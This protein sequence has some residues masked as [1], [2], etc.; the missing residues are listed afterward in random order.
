MSRLSGVDASFLYLESADMPMHVAGLTLYE[1]PPGF[2]GSFHAHFKAFFAGRVHLI[3]IFGKKLAHAPLNLDHPGWVDEDDLDLDYHIQGV[4]LP[5]PGTRA[6]LDAL[7]ARMHAQLMDRSKPL[8][9]FTV[10]EG[11]EDGRAALYSKVHH[12]AVDGS[13]G[14]IITR[15]L[16]DLTPEPRVVEPP[17]PKAPSPAQ[18]PK[19]LSTSLTDLMAGMIRQ[20]QAA[21]RAMPDML[22][23]LVNAVAPP[24]GKDTPITELFPNIKLPKL[25]FIAPKT[26]FNTTVG[27]ARAYASRSLLLADAKRIAKATDTKINDVVMAISGGALRKYLA[28]RKA[29]PKAPLLAFVP[30]STREAGN[31]EI[32]NQVSGMICPVGTNEA[33]PLKRL[34]DI[35]A[36]SSEAKDVAGSVKSAVPQDFAFL[37]APTI[38]NLMASLGARFRLADW[39]VPVANVTISNNAGPPVSLYCAGARVSALY[40]V[41]IPGHGIALNI[42]VQS[43]CDQLDFGITADAKAVPDIEML[44]DALVEAMDEIKTALVARAAEAAPKA[45]APAKPAESPQPDAAKAKTAPSGADPASARTVPPAVVKVASAIKA[46][47]AA[48]P[49]AKAKIPAA[50]AAKPAAGKAKP[51]AKTAMPATGARKPKATP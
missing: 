8:W 29:L 37:G 23:A 36:A 20:Q 47:K 14:M 16:Y 27:N 4:R 50:K 46:A 12:A 35:R 28:A 30:I 43:Y 18:A 10:I 11:L 51:A 9:Q 34:A 42:T 25:H 39:M 26:P 49:A 45:A 3:P 13:S 38:I 33:D 24:A 22:S 1:L 32:N 48:K 19:D 6:Q 21:L 41:S 5:A 31:T 40:P 17:A 7:I 44:A 2:R 15:A